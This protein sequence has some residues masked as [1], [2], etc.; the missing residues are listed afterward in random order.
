MGSFLQDLR[1]ALRMLAR[2]PG[3]AVVAVLTLALGIGANTAIFSVINAILLKPIPFPDPDRL[4][5]VWETRV[6]EGD[7]TNVVSAPNFHDWERQNHSFE[8]M[9]IFDSA[10]KGYALSGG[11][12]PERVSGVRVSAGFFDVLGVRPFLGRTFLP[13][14]ETLGKDHEVILNYGLW[15]RRY[16]GDPTLV[17]KTI[18][19]DG[20]SYTVVGVMPRDFQFQ[21]WSGLRQLWVPIGYTQGDKVRDSNSFVAFA[22]LKPGV[23]FA[24]AKDEMDA[25]GRR[26]MQQYPVENAGLGATISPMSEFQ[27]RQLRPTLQALLLIV[28]F[29]LLIACVNVANLTLARSAARQKEL[30]IRRALGASRF[31]I[32]GQLL[33]ESLLLALLGGVAGLFVASAGLTLLERIIPDNLRFLAFRHL[34]T[35]PMDG[36]VFAFALLISCVTGILFGLAPALGAG[37]SDLN[38]PLKEGSGRGV[39]QAGGRRMRN[40]LVAAEIALAL[41]VLAGAGLMVESV[42]RLL[43]VDPGLNPKNVL[44]MDMSLPQENIYYGPPVLARFCQDLDERAGT[45]PGVVSVSATSH[46][47]ISSAG[48]G[49]GFMIEGQPYLGPENS[50]NAGYSVACPNFFRTMGIPLLEGREFTERD[51]SGEPGVIVINQT[52]ALRYWPKEDALGKRINL[53]RP[54]SNEPWLTVVGVVRDFQKFA[55]DQ[56]TGPY[57]YRPYSQAAWPTMTIVARTASAPGAFTKP[58]K[59]ALAIIEPEQPVSNIQTMEEIV[60]D[61]VG[62]RRFPMQLLSAFAFLALA[63]AAVGIAGVVSYSVALRTHEMGIRLALGAQPTDVLRLVVS[64]SM[65]CAAAGVALGIAGALGAT[66]YLSSLLYD[67]KPADP[68]VLAAVSLLLVAVALLASYIPARRAARVDPMVALRYE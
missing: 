34:E 28:G 36:R 14:E 4:V 40:S 67:V 24:Q 2:S 60:I 31:R 12:E 11:K 15:K 51:T 29:V 59:D 64:G 25:I 9:A 23:T 49:R 19:I 30:A 27:I 57:F 50:P 13:E 61:S 33:T 68:I 44:T 37:R 42:A 47:P 22:R 17:G 58:I 6:H 62:S 16:G 43:R 3:F 8:G 10:G 32:V 53:G 41:V 5:L 65:T 54:G 7:H 52:M 35:I 21:F 66:R 1:Y 20:E 38:E 48:A 18:T 56:I 46:L 39:T 26:L 45:I 55:L 63:L